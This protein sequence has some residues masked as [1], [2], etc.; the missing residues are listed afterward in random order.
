MDDIRNEIRSSKSK[1]EKAYFI[2]HQAMRSLL[3]V[4]VL[5]AYLD[6]GASLPPQLDIACLDLLLA[7]DAAQFEG[8]TL[9]TRSI[10]EA[11]NMRPARVRRYI[12][13]LE[14]AGMVALLQKNSNSNDAT[15]VLQPKGLR[16]VKLAY[17]RFFSI[18][19]AF[20]N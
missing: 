3:W 10:P 6:R 8:R 16:Q 2:D 1:A 18:L 15:I 7:L 4:D 11:A 17:R 20:T 14:E 9:D 12:L 19:E 5:R 13:L